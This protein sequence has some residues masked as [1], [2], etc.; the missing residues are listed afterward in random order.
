MI[1]LCYGDS[2]TFGYDPR[3]FLGD[4][5]DTPWPEGV[6][7]LTGW[8]LRNS[9]LCGR[10]VPLRD[11]VFPKSADL[12]LVNALRGALNGWSSSFPPRIHPN[13]SSSPRRPCAG[14]NG[15]RMM[16]LCKAHRHCQGSTLVS[17]RGLEP[18]FSMP[19]SGTFRC[20]L[21][22]SILRRRGIDSLPGI[23]R[24]S[25]KMHVAIRQLLMY[26]NLNIWCRGDHAAT[27]HPGMAATQ[28]NGVKI[29][30]FNQYRRHRELCPSAKA[31]H[32]G[33]L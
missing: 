7:E 22:V 2:N 24:G 5:Y 32:W 31:G 14:A 3:S 27:V 15:S 10:R 30:A 16:P 19:D 12:I 26:N 8:Q 33:Q 18:G 20:A 13:A 1:I 29:P 4:R 9:G 6:G 28:G 21:T 11:T 17:V 25:C 23:W